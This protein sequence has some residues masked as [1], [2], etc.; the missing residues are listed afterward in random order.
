MR[1]VRAAGGTVR[2]TA[3]NHLRVEGPVGF[4]IVPQDYGAGGSLK[5]SVRTIEKKAGLD[6][7]PHL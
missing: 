7:G 2:V 6:I 4:A 5:Q 1:A 3:G